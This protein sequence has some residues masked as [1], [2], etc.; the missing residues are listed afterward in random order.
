MINIGGRARSSA[1]GGLLAVAL[2]ALSLGVG[3]PAASRAAAPQAVAAITPGCVVDMSGVIGWWRGQNDLLGQA[4]PELT[5]TVDYVDGMVGRGMSFDGTNT[6]GSD[7]LPPVS[8]ALTV[9]MWVKPA[10]AGFSG[11]TQALASRWDFPSTND[12]ARVFELLLDAYGNLVWSTDETGARRPVELRAAA[13]QFLDGGFHHVATTW[14]QTTIAIFIDGTMVASMP[15]QGGVLN[16]GQST[17]FRLGSE[18]G[19]GSS[20]H[21]KGVLDD[22]TVWSRALSQSE[23]AAIHGAGVS[24]KCTFVPVE[25]AKLTGSSTI[26]NDRFGSSLGVDGSTFV[27]GAPFSSVRTQFAG[28]AYVYTLLGTAWLQQA[29]LT[30]SD[31]ALVDFFGNAVDVDG[32]T[33]V[34]GAYGSN[35]G[36]TDAGAAYV[37]TRTGTTWTQQAKLV[38][39]DPNPDDRFGYSVAVDGDTI[40]IGSPFSD[41]GGTLEAGAAYVFTRTGTAWSQ[42][43]KLTAADAGAADLFGTSLALDG[44]TLIA[45]APTDDDAGTDSGAAYSFTRTAGIWSQQGKLVAA[46]AQA[47]DY[48]GYSL[49]L[50]GDTLAV[51]APFDDDLGVDSGSVYLDSRAAGVWGQ[52]AKLLASDGAAGNRFGH[53]VGF[54]NLSLVIG[55]PSSATVGPESG[56]AYVF[57]QSAGTWTE[58]ATLLPADIAVGDQFGAAVAVGI[59]IVIGANLDDNPGNNSGSAYVFAS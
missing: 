26:A 13:P 20:L 55:S 49:S 48:F 19:L 8:T 31:A 35:T 2:L 45:G 58:L 3:A 27:S 32:D 11:L 10:T 15:S 44:D 4:G 40:V 52:H 39:P 30:A 33:I 17:G 5:G 56:A 1:P 34:V 41:P 37:F 16:T 50:A 6:V 25:Q 53:A 59:N 18:L 23:I 36:F 29:T 46:D 21:F 47:G 12:S 54:G 9:E 28:A 14:D 51:G 24:G 38:A 57:S 7:L 42:Q 22:P 43:A